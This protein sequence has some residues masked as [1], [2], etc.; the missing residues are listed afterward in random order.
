MSSCSCIEPKKNIPFDCEVEQLIDLLDIAIKEVPE[1]AAQ[2]LR[3]AFHDAG[4]FN[5]N[6]PGEGGAN[7]CLMTSQDVLNKGENLGLEIAISVLAPVKETWE[8]LD[9]TCVEISNADF[10]Q[11]AGL[12][13]VIRQ[14]VSDW[15]P[16][17][18]SFF[19]RGSIF[20]RELLLVGLTKCN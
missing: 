10:L 16:S 12:L 9:T 5:Q 1:L 13:A 17:T 18:L 8:D 19:A 4:T 11:F 14:Q 3:A 6:V 20:N 2:S 7:G 15:F